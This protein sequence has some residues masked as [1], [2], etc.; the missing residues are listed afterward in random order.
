ML[1][2]A[3]PPERRSSQLTEVDADAVRASVSR[4]PQSVL[5]NVS[6]ISVHTV[7]ELPGVTPM[8]AL[9]MPTAARTS[10]ELAGAA[11]SVIDAGVG[12]PEKPPFCW[13]LAV[14]PTG[15]PVLYPVYATTLTAYM[16]ACRP[17]AP[18]V[19]VID[20]PVV[21]GA[22]QIFT[23]VGKLVGAAVIGIWPVKLRLP[24][25]IV[26]EAA[27]SVVVPLFSM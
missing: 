23:V 2:R 5:C 9:S 1:N 27:G 20:A 14:A 12:G 18:R 13:V 4:P 21:T 19:S 15:T 25:L 17:P 10:D 22:V 26:S 11:D 3:P 8:T 24:P 16:P 7:G 6:W